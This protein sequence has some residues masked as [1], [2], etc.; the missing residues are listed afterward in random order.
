MS[1]PVLALTDRQRRVLA[2]VARGRTNQE[3]A[4]ELFVHLETAKL[5]LRHVCLA[6]GAR[7]RTHAVALG[8]AY[9]VLGRGDVL[10]GVQ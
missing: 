10:G 4:D 8:F 5:D 7:D 3:I 6:L 1:A 2:L 9:G